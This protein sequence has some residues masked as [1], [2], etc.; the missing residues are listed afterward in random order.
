MQGSA[1]LTEWGGSVEMLTLKDVLEATRGRLLGR[2]PLD[3][4]V[5]G[6]CLDSRRIRRG[7]LFVALA[8]Q[9]HDGHSFVTD[10]F[11]RGAA[12]ALVARVP[13]GWPWVED[14]T[15]DGPPLILVPDV[16]EALH[17]LARA[18]RERHT[19]RV[20][21]VTGSVATATA[22]EL[23]A[24]VL[25]SRGQLLQGQGTSAPTHEVPLTLLGLT[26][27][28]RYAIV[29]LAGD[30]P[31]QIR[32]L[33]ETARPD[34]GV[35]LNVQPSLREGQPSLPETAEIQTELVEALPADGVAVLNVDDPLVRSM[36]ERTSASVLTFGLAPD[37]RVRATDVAGRGL[38]GTE[39][40]V[41]HA[42]RSVRVVLPLIGLQVVHAALAAAAVGL[43]EGMPLP[44]VAEGLAQASSAPR[45]VVANGINGTQIVDDTYD[46]DPE[47]MLEALNLL[48]ELGGR[49]VAVVGDMLGLGNAEEAEHVKVGSRAARVAD[50]LVTVGPRAAVAAAEARRVGLPEAAVVETVDNEAAVEQLKKLLRPGDTVLIKGS[51]GMALENVVRAIQVE[52]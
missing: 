5:R 11:A 17:R 50:L 36:A 24:A 23:I 12:A 15:D 49:K 14:A 4:A 33:A 13:P 41:H 48:T 42:G 32:Q 22:R 27:G 28:H 31:G 19:P 34:I 3:L 43:A 35:V 16:L 7:D 6:A 9:K 46:A 52:G 25:S 29:K 47:S 39:L 44:E 26:T 51:R 37:A 20:V 21:G 18:W 40:V 45:I 30:T 1:A 10:A 38:G 8:G 2:G